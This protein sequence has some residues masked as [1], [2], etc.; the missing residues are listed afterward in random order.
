MIEKK[1]LNKTWDQQVLNSA[2]NH[3]G[4]MWVCIR[5]RCRDDKGQIAR[6][7]RVRCGS[8][9][10]RCVGRRTALSGSTGPRWVLRR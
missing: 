10:E 9:L 2:E 4:Q 3:R 5:D 8:V 7:I 1:K 6:V